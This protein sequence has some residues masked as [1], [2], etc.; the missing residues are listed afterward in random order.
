MCCRCCLL[1]WKRKQGDEYSASSLEVVEYA[2]VP[3][4]SLL[5]CNSEILVIKTEGFGYGNA[6]PR[7]C[8]LEGN[9]LF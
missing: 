8:F 3:L 2:W 5:V 7:L 9:V 1:W 4:P 6:L